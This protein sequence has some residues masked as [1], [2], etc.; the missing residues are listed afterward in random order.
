MYTL[1][2]FERSRWSFVVLSR[3]KIFFRS[4]ASDLRPILRY[5][6]R[7]GPKR[8]KV[9]IFDKIV[10]RAA[11]L[12]FVLIQPERV[13]A[14]VLSERGEAVLRKHGITAE[15]RKLVDRIMAVSSPS[16]CQWEKLSQGQTAESFF[17]L[18]SNQSA[19]T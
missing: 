18:L 10:G 13:F 8:K 17:K 9:F 7:F 14:S 16:L 11:A 1:E 4:K 15:A 12:L 2:Q 3:G 19:M 5:L 6:K